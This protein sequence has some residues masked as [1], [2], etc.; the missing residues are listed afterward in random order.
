MAGHARLVL[1]L[2]ART[3]MLCRARGKRAENR[4]SC[5]AA[6]V[7]LIQL[8]LPVWVAWPS[9]HPYA[10]ALHAAR[11]DTFTPQSPLC[12]HRSADTTHGVSKIPSD[13]REIPTG[14]KLADPDSLPDIPA[15]D[16]HDNDGCPICR[17]AVM[18]VLFPA[19]EI[20]LAAFSHTYSVRLVWPV[21]DDTLS[22][23]VLLLARARAPPFS[24]S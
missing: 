19:A 24:A 22:T 9:I 14:H 1:I 23:H 11:H 8:V 7:I 5:L 15:G 10:W 4:F 17:L 3:L 12:T 13:T 6:L 16:C 18:P 2:A 21:S 20:R